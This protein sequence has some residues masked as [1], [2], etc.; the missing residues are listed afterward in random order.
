VVAV[1]S[2]NWSEGGQDEELMAELAQALRSP[3]PVPH[4]RVVGDRM[5]EQAR[6]AL[7]FRTHGDGVQRAPLLYDSFMDD[8][9][10]LRGPDDH[11]MLTFQGDRLGLEVELTSTGVAGQLVPAGEGTVRVTTADGVFA[12]VTADEIGYFTADRPA[13]GPIRLEC[14][15]A[16]GRVV[17]EW[18][19]I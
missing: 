2:P 15:T 9:P 8:E 19:P 12:T 18:V 7:A 4:D 10:S 13:R 16:D 3:A 17:T 6:R 11:R 14:E 1:H 5:L